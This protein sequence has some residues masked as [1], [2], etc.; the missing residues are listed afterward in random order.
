MRRLDGAVIRVAGY[1]VATCA[2]ET[3]QQD[4]L[5]WMAEDG[6]GVMMKQCKEKRGRLALMGFSVFVAVANVRKEGSYQRKVG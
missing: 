2:Y 1:L 3:T 5:S 4:E 6:R